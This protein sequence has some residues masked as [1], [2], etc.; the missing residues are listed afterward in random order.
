MTALSRLRLVRAILLAA[1]VL[2]ALAWGTAAGLSLLIGA[3]IVD[4]RAPL[5]LGARHVL[6]AVAAGTQLIVAA[7]LLWRDRAAT[8]LGRVALWIEEHHPSLAFVLVTAI[9]TGD[10]RLLDAAPRG[11]WAR[12]A[13]QRAARA[14]APPVV[15]I[16]VAI[17]ALVVLPPGVVARVRSPHAGDALDAVH[18]ARKS[19]LAPLVARVEPPAYSRLP[20]STLDEPSEVRALA[21]SRVVLRGRG[22][23]GGIDAVV[24]ADTIVATRAG[25]E[26]TIAIALAGKPEAL[27]VRDGAAQRIIALEPIVD[28]APA[29]TLVSP[30]RDSVL[31]VARGAIPLAAEVHD[32]FGIASAAFEYIVSSGEGENFT[33]KSGTVGAAHPGGPSTSLASS[34]DLGALGLKPGDI[35]HVRAVA[36]DANDVTGP[37]VGSSDTRAFRVART[38]EYDSVAVE[39][40]P[41]SDEDRSVVSERMLIMLAEA[42]EQRRPKLARDS[43]VSESRSI[44]TDQKRLRRTVGDIV[45]MRLGGQ[46]SGEEASDD[47]SPARARSMQEMLAR[48]DS[49]TDRSADP[50]D[51]GGGESPVVAVNKPLLE[52]YNAMWDASTELELGEPGRALPHMR[53]ALAAIQRA[54]QAE[55]VYLRGRPPQVV[56]DVA[57]ARLQGKDKG[58][59]SARAPAEADTALRARVARFARAVELVPRD[60]SA[61]VDTLLLLR[62]DALAAAPEFAAAL[63]DATEALRRGRGDDATAALARARRALAGPSMARDSIAR[64]GLVP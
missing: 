21:G 52:A 6:L 28:S 26:W 51:F 11:G 27:R 19:R 12:T 42:L 47:V 31:R 18:G 10:P 40:A 53:R 33:F 30:A 22:E 64:W 49:A 44:A 60:P 62:I 9:E 58:S 63:R 34:L 54:R 20:A 23:P 50:I 1:V 38:G 61:A 39:A 17:A 55:R 56:I 29:V 37:G 46:P 41:P 48:A 16:V 25:G 43:M 45:F 8:T 35:V 32:D 57:K 24:G 5:G 2:R 14:M 13:G 59:S 36:R 7:S 3:A 4:A 15:A